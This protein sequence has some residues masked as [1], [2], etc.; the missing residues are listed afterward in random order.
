MKKICLLFALAFCAVLPSF[1]SLKMDKMD[2][3]KWKWI[4]S[5][6]KYQSI[7]YEDGY[8]LITAK[9]E[10]KHASDYQNM[11]KTFARIPMRAKDN[12]KLTIKCIVPNFYKDQYV[13]LFNTSK[14]CLDDEESTG[15]FDTYALMMNGS[16]WIL[17]IFK[18]K[19]WSDMSASRNVK[20][21]DGQ[22]YNDVLPGKVKNPKDYPMEFVITK[23]R[24][25]AIIEINGIQI[26]KG[27]CELTEPCMG[28]MVPV[29]SSL[30]VDEV[31]VD[32]VEEED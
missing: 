28:F 32:Q 13:I 19:N 27:D 10:Y 31:I 3:N 12:Y 18:T 24:N 29:G 4:E 21:E 15:Q 14:Q 9:K 7:T 17:N 26:F 22:V 25:T 16:N 6:D 1:A 5:A 2:D 30:K 23:S 8:M 11:A 20:G